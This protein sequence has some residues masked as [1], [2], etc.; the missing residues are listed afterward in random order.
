MQFSIGDILHLLDKAILSPLLALSIPI[1]LHVSGRQQIVFA[2]SPNSILGWSLLKL[3]SLQKKAIALAV[4]ATLLRL[5]NY[6]SQRALNNAVVAHFKPKQEIVVVTGGAG[7]CDIC[8][9]LAS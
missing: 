8:Q 2:K 5:N 1:A 4:V 3:P 7:V 6:A 9:P